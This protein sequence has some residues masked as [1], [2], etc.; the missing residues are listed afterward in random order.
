[1]YSVISL[2]EMGYPLMTS[3]VMAVID[4]VWGREPEGSRLVA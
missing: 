3:I 2:E 4:K 1:M